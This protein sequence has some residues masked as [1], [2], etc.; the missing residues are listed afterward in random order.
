MKVNVKLIGFPADS[1]PA[2]AVVPVAQQQ[3][4]PNSVEVE[5]SATVA[6]LAGKLDVQ[7]EKALVNG[8][9]AELDTPIKEG[10]AVV[11]FGP[12]AGVM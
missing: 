9:N 11:F 8:R 4:S 10:D 2:G 7:P 6:D 5:P 3:G 1:E 12:G